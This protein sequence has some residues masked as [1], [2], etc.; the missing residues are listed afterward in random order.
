MSKLTKQIEK[1]EHDRL[2]LRTVFES[3]ISI[4]KGIPGAVKS[5]VIAEMQKAL[6][7]TKDPDDE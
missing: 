5:S 2:H 7:Y 6:D 3:I 4:S 1:L